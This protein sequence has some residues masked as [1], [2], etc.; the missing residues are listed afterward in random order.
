MRGYSLVRRL[1]VPVPVWLFLS[2]G[3][4]AARRFSKSWGED[5]CAGGIVFVSVGYMADSYGQYPVYD[6]LRNAE[7]GGG[8]LVY[9]NA[10][11]AF[12]PGICTEKCANRSVAC[13]GLSASAGNAAFD[14]A[15]CGFCGMVSMVGGKTCAYAR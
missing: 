5:F 1:F 2:G 12:G 9:D 7:C 11:E 8:I 6:H 15:L 14:A 10:G 4:T 3:H 13:S